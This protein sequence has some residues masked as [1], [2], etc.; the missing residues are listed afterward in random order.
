MNALTCLFAATIVTAQTPKT[1]DLER[2][3]P[4]DKGVMPKA[5]YRVG[6]SYKGSKTIDVFVKGKRSKAHPVIY[7]DNHNFRGRGTGDRLPRLA[8]Q[9]VEVISIRSIN[10]VLYLTVRLRL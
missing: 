1:I 8:G 7:I 2:C 3:R 9:Q 4:G 5:D 10:S 6:G